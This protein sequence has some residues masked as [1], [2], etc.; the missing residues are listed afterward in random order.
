MVKI[1]RL[2][3]EQ[4][5]RQLIKFKPKL[6]FFIPEEKFFVQRNPGKIETIFRILGKVI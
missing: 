6:C 3:V 2:N 4:I 5:L 1:L